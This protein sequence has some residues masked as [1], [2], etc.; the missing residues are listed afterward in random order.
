MSPEQIHAYGQQLV[1]CP[2]CGG[3]GTFDLLGAEETRVVRTRCG[4]CG[5]VSA[6][7]YPS[8]GNVLRLLEEWPEGL[9]VPQ[10]ELPVG[11]P[12][13]VNYGGGVDSTA[14]LVHLVS[15][16]LRPDLILF[17][18]TGDEKPETYAYLEFFDGW[19]QTKG[20]PGI[21]RVAYT[22]VSAPYTTLEGNCLSNETLPSISFR[23]K[24]C[25]L[26]FKAAVMDAFL[27]GISRGPNQ[28]KGWAPAL[29]AL[30]RGVKPVKL[31]GYDNGPLDSCRAVDVEEDRYFRYRY[32]LRQIKWSRE[33]CITAIRKAGLP[34]PVK[35][36][37]FYCASTKDWELYW[38]AAEHP[39]LIERGLKI[40]D[41]AR[42]GKHGLGNVKG[43]RGQKESWREWCEKEGIIAP[44][45]RTVIADPA[46]M[47]EKARELK[48]PMESNLDFRLP[49]AQE[50]A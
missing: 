46:R 27:L 33:D 41:V 13:I 10:V 31:I 48:P 20:F 43:L 28:K 16:G 12:I 5:N 29:E 47:L 6:Q 24:N 4:G 38:M 34:V 49:L 23:K 15:V 37:C 11:A 42:E 45:S 3:Q 39:D 22:P 32:P 7:F 2:H 50:A 17:A 8:R 19:L 9:P 21:T 35:S 14:L 40:E 36:A 30:E 18:D 25:T 26:K 1:L 44:G